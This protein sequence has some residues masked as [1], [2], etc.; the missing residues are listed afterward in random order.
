[1]AEFIEVSFK[2]VSR[3]AVIDKLIRAKVAKLEKICGRMVSCRVAV[4]QPQHH[5]KRGNPYRVVIEMTVPPGHELVAGELSDKGEALPSVIR[6]AFHAAQRQ[7]KEL[8]ERQ[9]GTVK[10]H[11]QQEAN[12][13]VE[14][15]FPRRGYGFIK[16]V[17]SQ[18]EVY[19]HHNSVLHNAFARIRPGTAVH[20]TS[21]QGDKGLQA[22]SVEIVNNTRAPVGVKNK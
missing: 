2:D 22:R 7:L 18:E 20:F 11:P 16:T 14:K 1:M 15:L 6:R 5:Q 12:G 10:S 8:T 19:F 21:E 9:H 4:E 3:N 13:I 17:D